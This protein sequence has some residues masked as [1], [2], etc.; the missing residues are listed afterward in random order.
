M[1]KVE[2]KES[3]IYSLDKAPEDPELFFEE[4]IKIFSSHQI[5]VVTLLTIDEKGPRENL[6]TTFQFYGPM[7]L[8]LFCTIRFEIDTSNLKVFLQ[9][10]IEVNLPRG[11]KVIAKRI[12]K[13]YT[14][15]ITK[16]IKQAVDESFESKKKE[17]DSKPTTDDP[18]KKLKLKFVNGEISEEEYLH[19]KKILEE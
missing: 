18:L 15:T 5:A 7:S 11:A 1:K 2:F 6:K 17:I 12:E 3:Q 4:F 9:P 13:T 8:D 10:A 14:P 16:H 19:K